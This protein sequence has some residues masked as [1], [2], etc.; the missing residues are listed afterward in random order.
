LDSAQDY[1]TN[2]LFRFLP[3]AGAYMC[4]VLAGKSNGEEKDAAWKWK[5]AEELQCRKGKEF[6]ES[7]RNCDKRELSEYEEG[8]VS[9]L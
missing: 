8:A 3:V 6:G 1:D 5:S 4:N 2:D 9:K 7:P